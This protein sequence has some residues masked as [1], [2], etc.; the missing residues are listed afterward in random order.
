MN[1]NL[2]MFG[3]DAPVGLIT[4]MMR[5]MAKESPSILVTMLGTAPVVAAVYGYFWI[6]TH[7]GWLGYTVAVEGTLRLLLYT[8]WKL[9]LPRHRK[10]QIA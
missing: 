10:G 6:R 2:I 7:A 4:H 8:G 1:N 3:P 9:I 5:T